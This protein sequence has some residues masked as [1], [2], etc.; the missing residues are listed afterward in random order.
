M[1]LSGCYDPFPLQS[2]HCGDD[3]KHYFFDADKG[4]C[5][6]VTYHGC[7]QTRNIFKSRRECQRA[8][9]CNLDP[10]WGY[11]C[12]K[13]YQ[14]RYWYEAESGMCRLFWFSGCGG[15]H[16]RFK[17]LSMCETVCTGKQRTLKN[18]IKTLTLLLNDELMEMNKSWVVWYDSFCSLDT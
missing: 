13:K 12:G 18:E 7:G 6:K 5:T 11:Y 17:R 4:H 8:C 16:N 3:R 2:P 9:A 1:Y 15:N 14:V 10:T